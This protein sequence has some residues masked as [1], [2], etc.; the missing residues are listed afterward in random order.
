MAAR[1]SSDR[2]IGVS[3]RQPV[4]RV[5]AMDSSP[6]GSA[7]FATAPFVGDALSFVVSAVVLLSIR[8]R[9]PASQSDTT[10]RETVRHDL[11]EG[12]EFLV[13]HPVLRLLAAIIGSLAFAQALVTGVLVLYCVE[14]LHLS[15]AGYGLFIGLTAS[16]NVV[17]AMAA[18]QVKA[19][20]GAAGAI[21][22]AALVSGFGLVLAARTS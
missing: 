8:R 19:R 22:T 2:V 21:T 20:F 12:V 9:L 11:R 3:G 14:V 13:H 7:A 16:G 18:P 10:H 1:R 6:S 17:G 5:S 4:S 15:P